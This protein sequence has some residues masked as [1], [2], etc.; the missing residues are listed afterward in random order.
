MPLT[1]NELDSCSMKYGSHYG[2]IGITELKQYYTI[3]KYKM[4]C[5]M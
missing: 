5:I 3:T 2:W 4:Q 1:I